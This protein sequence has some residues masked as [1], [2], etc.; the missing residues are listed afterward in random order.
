MRRHDPLG[1]I[2]AVDDG[3]L[4][5][6]PG[7]APEC[8]VSG[9]AFTA[10]DYRDGVGIAAAPG[11]GVW[12]HA[13]RRWQPVWEGDARS[14]S[15]TAGGALYIGAGDSR[16][17]RSDDRGSTW[18]ELEG[19]LNVI[20]HGNLAPASR[21]E[22][23]YVAAVVAVRDGFVVGI[24]GGGAWHSRDGGKSWLRRTHGLDP[25]VHALYVHPEHLDRLFATT[26]SGIFRSDDEGSSWLQSLSGLDRAWGGTLAVLPGA[27]DTLVLAAARSAPGREGALFRSPNGGVSWSRLLLDGEDEW[28]RI[29]VVVRPW[30]WED[31]VFVAGGG[32]LWASHDRGKQWMA[33]ASGLP[34][35]NAIAASI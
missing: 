8:V 26:A 28:E 17:W 23:A 15:A 4:Q 1:V 32:R 20:R 10:V 34:V 18:Q 12:V 21:H 27:P 24:A 13:G 3:L 9:P 2:L 19:V 30:D 31:L 11:A 22:R 14:V 5:V 25:Q 29:P 6:T 35:A 33:L 16:L 7:T